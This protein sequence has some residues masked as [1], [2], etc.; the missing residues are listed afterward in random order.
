MEEVDDDAY[1]D[2]R[3]EARR[4]VQSDTNINRNSLKPFE[5][6]G[7]SG[8]KK[9]EGKTSAEGTGDDKPEEEAD[10]KRDSIAYDTTEG[11]VM[12]GYVNK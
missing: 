4:K 3:S 11:W 5:I 12:E 1:S 9:E 2:G 7:E 8:V 10:E 6:N